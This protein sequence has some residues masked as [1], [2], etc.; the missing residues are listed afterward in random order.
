MQGSGCSHSG[1][2]GSVHCA[3]LNAGDVERYGGRLQPRLYHL[4]RARQNGS[5]RTTT[6]TERVTETKIQLIMA[7]LVIGLFQKKK[8]TR[9]KFMELHFI[10]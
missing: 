8:M 3:Q 5:H 6:P 10:Y 2:G 7:V 1:H 4:Q 9:F